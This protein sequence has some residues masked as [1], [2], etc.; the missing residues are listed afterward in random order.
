MANAEHRV[1]DSFAFQTRDDLVALA[2]NSFEGSFLPPAE[3]RAWVE[4]VAR[5]AAQHSPSVPQ[6]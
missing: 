5:Y 6:T 2:R 1:V 4:R 3:K